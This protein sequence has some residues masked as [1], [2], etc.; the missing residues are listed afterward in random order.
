MQ[1]EI[2]PKLHV[3]IALAR[4]GIQKGQWWTWEDLALFLHDRGVRG[5]SD[6]EITQVYDE[7]PIPHIPH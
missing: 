3:P 7:C 5:L 2:D 1:L 4:I 6:E